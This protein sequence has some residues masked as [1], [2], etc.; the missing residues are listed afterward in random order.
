MELDANEIRISANKIKLTTAKNDDRYIT[1]N[2]VINKNE[3][4]YEWL[5][6]LDE[7]K[8]LPNQENFSRM[9][10]GIWEKEN[11]ITKKEGNKMIESINLIDLYANKHRESIEKETKEKVEELRKKCDVINKYNELVEQ[12]EKDCDE[13]YLSQFTE[14]E[15]SKIL[16]NLDMIDDADMQ[17]RTTGGPSEAKYYTNKNFRNDDYYK[18]I[19][20]K[21]N[22]LSEIN[23]LVK[24][25]KAHVGIAKTK[26]EVEEIL[27][28]YGIIDKK[29]KL[30][31]K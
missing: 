9:F 6:T 8:M 11:P 27:T 16:I 12:F 10:L 20:E 17:L 24:T 4:L 5:K 30:V 1:T 22:K 25:V 28:R 13:L 2:M 21:E 29:G 7:N 18:L 3:Q 26:E 14:E 19:D 23:D 31:I 15:K